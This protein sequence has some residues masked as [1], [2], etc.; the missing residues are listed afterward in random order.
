M[1]AMMYRSY[2]FHSLEGMEMPIAHVKVGYGCEQGLTAC[3]RRGD[4]APCSQGVPIGENLR[5]RSPRGSKYRHGHEHAKPQHADRQH[6]QQLGCALEK[7]RHVTSLA[8]MATGIGVGEPG[9]SSDRQ[10]N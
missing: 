4:E 6:S 7:G 9:G 8:A 2:F 3:S 5:R 1:S 10:F